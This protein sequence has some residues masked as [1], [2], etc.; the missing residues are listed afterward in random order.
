MRT[1]LLS[2][3]RHQLPAPPLADVG[4][5]AL[6]APL[7][8]AVDEAW[9]EGLEDLLERVWLRREAGKEFHPRRYRSS[10]ACVTTEELLARLEADG[11]LRVANGVAE[12][13]AAGEELAA[14][15]VRR[16][17]LAERL[18]H[19]LFR[20]EVAD[21]DTFACR[22]EHI[23]DAEVTE[24]VCTL[25]GHPP[26]CPHGHRIP[27]GPCCRRAERAVRPLVKPLTDF[28]PGARVRVVF[29]TPSVHARLDRLNSLGLLPGEELQIH[30]IQP[31]FV[32]RLGATEVAIEKDVAREIYARK[33]G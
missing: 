13:T 17:R 5:G 6:V 9:R 33:L 18:F 20:T 22:F 15:V 3:L 23:L 21:S 27:P 7:E 16:H 14:Q 32:I 4:A 26:T 28:A 24:A 30:Q 29:I 31:A 12:L 8:A 11:L 25:L 10:V 2:E 19:D 1:D